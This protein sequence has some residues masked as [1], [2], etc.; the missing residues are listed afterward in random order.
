MTVGDGP[1]FWAAPFEQGKEFG[2]HGFPA[3]VDCRKR[4][5]RE[6]KGAARVSTT[7]VIVATDAALSKAQAKRLAIMAQDGLA[8]AIV[9]IHSPLDGDVVF[10]AATGVRP[11]ADPPFGLMR[12]GSTAAHTVARAVARAVYEAAALPFPGRAAG[13]SRQVSAQIARRH[14]KSL[15]AKRR[16]VDERRRAGHHVGDQPA[17]DRAKRQAPMAMTVGEPQTRPPGRTADDRT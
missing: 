6:T 10:A 2:G 8:R 15:G 9:P 5:T 7:L 3:V 14:C 17:C 16:R 13:L 4:S 11:L 1:W 12:L